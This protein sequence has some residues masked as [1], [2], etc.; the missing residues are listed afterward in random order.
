MS[1]SSHTSA[2]GLGVFRR[3][4]SMLFAN[5]TAPMGWKVE[6]DND[7]M[8]RIVSSVGGATAGT[9]GMADAVGGAAAVS[10]DNYTLLE[11]DIPSHTHKQ[12]TSSGAGGSNTGTRTSSGTPEQVV[13]TAA[14]GGGGAH[15]HT[16]SL[17]VKYVDMMRCTKV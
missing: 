14:T 11:A 12:I 13:D 15:A 2:F 3:G 8:V 5:P 16:L 6:A 17:D 7:T 9:N 4:T 10:V 1:Y